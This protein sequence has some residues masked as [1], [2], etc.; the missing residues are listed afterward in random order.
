VSVRDLARVENDG[1]HE[2][3][4]AEVF[5]AVVAVGFLAGDAG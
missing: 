1:A 2:R 4:V 3:A 5:Q